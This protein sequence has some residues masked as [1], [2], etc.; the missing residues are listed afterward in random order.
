MSTE[1]RDW[2]QVL[3]AKFTNALTVGFAFQGVLSAIF[4]TSF[5]T[6]PSLVRLSTILVLQPELFAK[7]VYS[8]LCVKSVLYPR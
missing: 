5:R 7:R 8:T 1:P 6:L 4:S 3:S 2:L